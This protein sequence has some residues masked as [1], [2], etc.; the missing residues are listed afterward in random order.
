[1]TNPRAAVAL[2]GFNGPASGTM[3]VEG[4]QKDPDHDDR[5][6]SGLVA[7]DSS[8]ASDSTPKLVPPALRAGGIDLWGGDECGLGGGS[9]AT[10][11]YKNEGARELHQRKVV[12]KAAR[13]QEILLRRI[14]REFSGPG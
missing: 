10:V 9:Q 6:L 14:F 1:M 12:R 13:R 3:F 4:P 8:T 7:V 2:N 11:P 5:F